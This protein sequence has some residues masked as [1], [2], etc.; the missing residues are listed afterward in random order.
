MSDRWSAPVT[1]QDQGIG[2]NLPR[3]FFPPLAPVRA[4]ENCR[5][6]AAS[7]GSGFTD[8]LAPFGS[9]PCM[10]RGVGVPADHT[11]C[12]LYVRDGTAANQ[13]L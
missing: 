13:I 8:P 12:E 9:N 3:E 1:H 6:H 2:R 4:P 5:Y 11:P 10:A 7:N